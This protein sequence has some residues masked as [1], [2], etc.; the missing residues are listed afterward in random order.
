MVKKVNEEQDMIQSSTKT[1]KSDQIFMAR[2]G[3]LILTLVSTEP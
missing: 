1:V 3:S 2:L